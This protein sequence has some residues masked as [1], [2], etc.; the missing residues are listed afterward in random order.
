MPFNKAY[1]TQC[2]TLNKGLPIGAQ[3]SKLGEDPHYEL[4]KE[5]VETTRNI[6]FLTIKP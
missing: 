2:F 6:V 5:Q 1:L 3:L 4:C